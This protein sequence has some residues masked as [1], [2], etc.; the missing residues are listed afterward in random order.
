V[1][2][3]LLAEARAGRETVVLLPGAPG[4]GKTRLLEAF[5]PPAAAAGATVLRGGASQ[6]EGMPPYVPFL[7]ALGGYVAAAPVGRL[8]AQV[9]ARAAILAPLLPEIPARLG[10]PAAGHPL[11]P[12]Q[13]RFRLYEAV[14]G[15]LAAIAAPGPAV[16]LLDDL[17]WADAA[18][19]DLLVHVAGR[20]RAAPVLV[21][22]AYRSGE[23]EANPPLLRSLA[24][25]N[26]RRL[27]VTLPLP[28]LDAAASR[29]LAGHL[30]GG[31]IAPDAA[32][33]LH[34]HGEGNPFFLEELLRA[35]VEEGALVRRGGRWEL[36]GPPAPL[37]PPRVA[38]AIRLRLDRLDPAAVEALRVAA[39][40]GRR[41]EPAL[42]ARVMG[43]DVER[44]EELLLSAARW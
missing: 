15:F 39:V 34:R 13:E 1:L 20:L 31:A 23:A 42:L 27:S 17:Q 2:G 3:E 10:P 30:L 5:L 6:A 22:G 43:L 44:V 11:G 19:F 7:E 24:E 35:M 4:I 14:A 41:W 21:V 18:T 40:V 16:L 26:R 38:E 28:P 33:L 32:D 25:L 8:R 12:E 37:L 29:E 36:A 9:G